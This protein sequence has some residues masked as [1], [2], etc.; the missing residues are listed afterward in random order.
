M[1]ELP[2]VK[3]DWIGY[4]S[5]VKL[6]IIKDYAGAYSKILSA[7][8]F[9]HIYI[10]G[11]A[12]PGVSFSK[13]T[14]EFIFGSPLKAL[15]EVTPPFSEYHFIDINKNK[16]ALLNEVVGAVPNVHVHAGDCNPILLDL[17]FPLVRYEDYRRGLCVLDPYGLHLRWEVLQAAGHM[18]TIEIFLNF[19]IMD[20]NRRVIRHDPS[21]VHKN[22]II[23]M[24]T[25]WG[26]ESWKEVAYSTTQDLFRHP[27]KVDNETLA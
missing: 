12:G 22:D 16:A 23:R 19:P 15:V 27:T 25:F 24:N 14:S 9:H 26:D 18:G 20:I 4:W 17:V 5:E 3:F 6:D 7:H 21:K 13:K 8:R 2:E 10:D 1:G 11:F